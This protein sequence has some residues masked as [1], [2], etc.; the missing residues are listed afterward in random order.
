MEAIADRITN[1]AELANVCHRTL[2]NWPEA[3]AAV[4][5]GSRARSDHHPYSDWDIAI[6]IDGE[7]QTSPISEKRFPQAGPLVRLCNVDSLV[8]SDLDLRT[9]RHELGSLP[10]N[11]IMDGH[12][13][14]GHWE[15]PDMEGINLRLEPERFQR[16][17]NSTLNRMGA[18]LSQF[19]DLNEEDT[20]SDCF[21]SCGD[22]LQT[23]ADGAELLAKC[24]IERRG[25]RAK[26][27]HDIL[28][29]VSDFIEAQPEQKELAQRMRGLNGDTK[30]DH[31]AMY[32]DDG[33]IDTERCQNAVRRL[34]VSLDL[35]IS[36][37]GTDPDNGAM[38]GTFR[39]LAKRAS[40]K[41]SRWMR[42]LAEPLQEKPDDGSVTMR[43][44]QTILDGQNSIRLATEDFS[45]RLNTL[46]SPPSAE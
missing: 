36:E 4:L 26:H 40:R 29:L 32:G 14:S 9:R 10:V 25:V 3:R 16:R 20:W 35:W 38:A 12:L 13:L 46:S 43:C 22:F 5:F 15:R 8:V 44:A 11:I 19:T 42:I 23:S 2:A 31:M 30:N 6:I 45:R 24:I 34:I 1:E 39:Y 17:M 21:T 27:T 41:A 18:A 37:L 28:L 7:T 33:G